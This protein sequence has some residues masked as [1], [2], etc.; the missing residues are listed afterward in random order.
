G[1][2]VILIAGIAVYL[3]A[4]GSGY[5]RISRIAVLPFVNEAGDQNLEYLSDGI[6]ETLINSLSELP[7]LDV[8]SRNSVF[9]YKG[10]EAD[11]Q[12]AGRELKVGGVLTGRI[13]QRDVNYTISAE[14]VDVAS[15]RHLWG[16]IYNLRPSEILTVQDRI[17]EEISSKLRISPTAGYEK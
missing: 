12:A 7:G 13:R 6:T 14:L 8:M 9:H 1:L 16:R 17:A 2:L 4:R 3:A 10:R 5:S 11:A 15:N